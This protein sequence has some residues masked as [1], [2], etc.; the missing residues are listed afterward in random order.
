MSQRKILYF[1]DIKGDAECSKIF[2]EVKKEKANI[3]I[4]F[5]RECSDGELLVLKEFLTNSGKA[6]ITALN[7]SGVG[8]G[9]FASGKLLVSFLRS[10]HSVEELNL[11]NNN[12]SY[13][14]LSTIL[15]ALEKNFLGENSKKKSILPLKS[16]DISNNFV[17]DIGRSL[18]ISQLNQFIKSSHTLSVLKLAGLY[19]GTKDTFDTVFDEKDLFNTVK[20]YNQK[21]SPAQSVSRIENL[22]L[23]NNNLTNQYLDILLSCNDIEMHLQGN[24]IELAK[25][26]APENGVAVYLDG[27]FYYSF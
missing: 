8:I 15:N 24:N 1:K 23:S 9:D 7:L 16:L 27:S 10:N 11:S 18:F 12:I 3:E 19:L 6:C 2:Q 26:F 20:I 22:D 5:G 21:S 13:N 14:G 25:D 17:E 4:N